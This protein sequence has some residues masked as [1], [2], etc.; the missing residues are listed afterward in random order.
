MACVLT[1]RTRS[2]TTPLT[3]AVLLQKAAATIDTLVRAAETT[4]VVLES[5]IGGGD[6]QLAVVEQVL[7][8]SARIHRGELHRSAHSLQLSRGAA[9]QLVRTPKSA[10]ARLS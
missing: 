8:W 2:S 6:Q 10:A 4:P 9:S 1:R 7:H 5:I 3:S